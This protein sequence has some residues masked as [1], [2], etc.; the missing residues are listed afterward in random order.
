MEAAGQYFH[1][2]TSPE[3]SWMVPPKNHSHPRFTTHDLCLLVPSQIS[4]GEV[5]PKSPASK[6]VASS[7][8]PAQA[9]NFWGMV[10]CPRQPSGLCLLQACFAH[11]N[12]RERDL[13]NPLATPSCV[14]WDQLL[15]LSELPHLWTHS[16]VSCT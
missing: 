11:W 16:A 4:P 5:T 2:N 10:C 9:L 14:T 3:S 12:E 15:H 6:L 1:D 13:Q 7:D 8:G